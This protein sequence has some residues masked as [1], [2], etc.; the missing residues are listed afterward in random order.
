[1]DSAIDFVRNGTPF[2]REGRKDLVQNFC[3]RLPEEQLAAIPFVNLRPGDNFLS[4]F[5]T[6]NPILSLKR[7]GILE[8]DRATAICPENIAELLARLQEAYDEYGI[9]SG[10]HIFNLDEFGFSTRTA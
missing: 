2:S 4:R 9:T 8:K 1:M 5:F 3:E 6:R 10:E 7:H